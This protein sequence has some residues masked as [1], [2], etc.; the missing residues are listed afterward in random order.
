M[1]GF[2]SLTAAIALAAALSAGAASAWLT[3][4]YYTAKIASIE[5]RERQAVADANAQAQLAAQGFE[6]WKANQKPKVVTITREVDRVIEIEREWSNAPIP[7][8][9]RDV[10]ASA[11]GDPDQPKPDRS[12]FGAFGFAASD[13]QR[14]AE[15]LHIRP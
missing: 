2:I 9:V 3:R 6:Q 5:A 13:K 10:L 12:L 15:G 11:H 4:M 14:P 1:R 8:R 7:E